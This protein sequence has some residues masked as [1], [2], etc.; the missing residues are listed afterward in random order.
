M[1]TER[2][3]LG[4]KITAN[5]IEVDKAKINLI[6]GL[7]PPTTVK[8]IR[9]FLGHAGF[10]RRFIKEFSKISKPL[11]NLLMKDVKFDFSSDYMIAF[12]TL[13]EKLSNAPVVVFPDWSQP[14][15]IM[16]DA[17]DTAV[18][19]VL[20]QRKDKIF[21][22]IYYASRTLNEAHLN[23]ATTEKELLAVVFAFD[24]F[25][26]DLE[27]KDKKGTEN[28]VADHLSRLEDPPLEFSEIKEEF[29]DEHIF[30]VD[31]V[32]TQPPWYADIANCLVGIWT[33][34][35][36]SYQQRKKL[37]SDAKYYLWNEPYLFK[38]CADNII[39]RYVP[40]EEM[41][42][43]LYHCHDGAIGGHMLQTVRHLKYW[44]PD[45]SGQHSS[46]MP[47]HMLHNVTCV[48][49]KGQVEV[50][51]REL[52]RILEKTVRIS[53]KDWSL[54]LDEA[55]WAYRTAFKTPIGT[56]PYKLVFGKACHLPA[57]LEHKAFWA[58]KALNFELTCVGKKRF[59]LVNELEEL[60]LEAYK[61]ARIFKE[62]TKIW[63]DNFIRQKSFKI[64]DQVLL[65]N[66]TSFFFSIPELLDQ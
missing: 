48:R 28:Q 16:C 7:P 42:K 50:S 17:S 8:G 14:F 2:I 11:T 5:G 43:I 62:K 10:Y 41:A 49:K 57:E 34:Q 53:R 63:H 9:N 54:K 19:A 21:R 44:R 4:H 46:K 32:V 66:S 31:S 37:I 47:E 26:F 36:I 52:K 33:P 24:K 18:G 45:F 55:L 40:E 27:I 13:K 65:Y 23:Y 61:N 30:S 64:G 6:A 39:R 1:V 15:E 58:L 51:N 29:P 56:S 38:I 25:Q 22:L 59:F 60:R 20:G 35:D 3:V 12:D